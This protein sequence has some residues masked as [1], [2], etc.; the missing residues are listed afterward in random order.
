MGIRTMN[1]KCVDARL[2]LVE[3]F[4]NNPVFSKVGIYEMSRSERFDRSILMADAAAR[5]FLETGVGMKYVD[6]IIDI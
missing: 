1:P 6:L 4:S 5:V 2:R 3:S